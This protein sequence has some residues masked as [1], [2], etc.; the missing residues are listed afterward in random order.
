MLA[1][2][3]APARRPSDKQLVREHA[4][5][6]ARRATQDWIDGRISTKEHSAVH[7]RAKHVLAGKQPR[8]FKGPNGE[9]KMKG[10]M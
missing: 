5:S 8:E 2:I 10:L 4:K 6:T 7:E 9:R 1:A 3:M